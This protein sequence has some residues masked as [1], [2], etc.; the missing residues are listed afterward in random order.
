MPGGTAAARTFAC[1][2]VTHL[3]LVFLAHNDPCMAVVR[4]WLVPKEGADTS[5][6]AAQL[7]HVCL[8]ANVAIH[9]PTGVCLDPDVQ[10]SVPLAPAGACPLCC[11]LEVRWPI[12]L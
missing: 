12:S 1:S 11:Q 5:D 10:P 4:V 6:L 8:L 7:A 2:P 3:T 9:W